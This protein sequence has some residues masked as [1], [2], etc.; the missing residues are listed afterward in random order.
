MLFGGILVSLILMA[1][2]INLAVSKRSNTQIRIASVVALA[3]MVLTVIICL[4]IAFTDTTVPQDPS[5]FIVG[6]PPETKT[7]GGNSIALIMLIAF[8]ITVFIMV[9]ILAMKENRKHLTDN[10]NTGKPISNW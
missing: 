10:K 3:V 4:F 1:V 2:M 8:L 6:E 5:R 9:A 7:D